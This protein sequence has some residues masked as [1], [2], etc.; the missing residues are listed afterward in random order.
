[1]N[2]HFIRNALFSLP[3]FLLLYFMGFEKQ[4]QIDILAMFPIRFIPCILS[5]ALISVSV[6]FY[7]HTVLDAIRMESE[8]RVRISRQYH[9]WISKNSAFA[10]ILMLTIVIGYSLAA[11][12]SIYELLMCAGMQLLCFII[13]LISVKWLKKERFAYVFL[14]N[15]FL[16]IVV[17]IMLMNCNLL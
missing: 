13:F 14:V 1:M 7:I 17:R 12:F 2:K 5:L 16:N 9:R 10:C 4:T 15:I 8:V 6:L 3:I 11:S